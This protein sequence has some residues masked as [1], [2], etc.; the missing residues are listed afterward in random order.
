MYFAP[1]TELVGGFKPSEKYES[2]IGLFPQKS[3]WKLK[4]IFETTT[5]RSHPP[6][7]LMSAL[8]T[9]G[10]QVVSSSE[11]WPVT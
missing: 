10:G 7:P 2:Q 3:G 8:S 5:Y 1:E 6:W 11:P 4:K 9:L